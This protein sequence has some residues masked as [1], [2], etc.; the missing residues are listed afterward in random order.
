MIPNMNFLPG[1]VWDLYGT[2]K[3]K[4]LTKPCLE[5]YGTCMEPL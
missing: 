5:A 1:S 3:Y 2:P 4:K